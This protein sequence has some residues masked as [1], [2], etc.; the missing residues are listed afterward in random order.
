MCQEVWK[1]GEWK[2]L[3]A[4]DWQKIFDYCKTWNLGRKNNSD[5][6]HQAEAT[7]TNMNH[8]ISK[9]QASLDASKKRLVSFPHTSANSD[10]SSID[11]PDSIKGKNKRSKI[12]KVNEMIGEAEISCYTQK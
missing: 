11:P 12:A 8:Q 5:N 2:K 7:K 10:K 4:N 3:S 9:I 6:W 1:V